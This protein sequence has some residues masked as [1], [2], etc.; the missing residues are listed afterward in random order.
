LTKKLVEDHMFPLTIR[1]I[2]EGMNALSK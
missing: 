1:G 2:E